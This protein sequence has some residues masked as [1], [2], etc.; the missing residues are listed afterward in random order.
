[1]FKKFTET[2][3]FQTLIE[4]HYIAFLSRG[5]FLALGWSLQFLELLT[6]AIEEREAQSKVGSRGNSRKEKYAG[7]KKSGQW[8]QSNE[9]D[10]FL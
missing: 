8:T 1:M 4:P 5:V 10:I 3:S 2:L 6:L 7:T 9:T